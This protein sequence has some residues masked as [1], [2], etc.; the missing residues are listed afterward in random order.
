MSTGAGLSY[1]NINK[2]FVSAIDYMD[3]REILGKILD[4]RNEESCF[5]DVM[6]MFGVMKPTKAVTFHYHVNE[7]LYALGIVNANLASTVATNASP[8]PV[9][10]VSN[11]MVRVGDLVLLPSTNSTVR[12]AIVKT[13][14]GTTGIG[15]ASI[16]GANIA[17]SSGASLSFFSG[18]YGEGSG[19][20]ES[21]RYDATSYSGQLQ[22]FKDTFKITDVQWGSE[23]EVTFNGKPYVFK[24]AEFETALKFRSAISNA[25][26]L[27][28]PTSSTFGESATLTD[29]SG[30]LG[31]T[32][33]TTRGLD[34]WI[35][36]RGGIVDTLDYSNVMT[37]AD[38]KNLNAQL[39]SK[40]APKKY[41]VL[42]GTSWNQKNDDLFMNLGSSPKISATG[43][44]WNIN[45]N[46]NLDLETFSIY[47]RSFAKK[48]MDW[49]NHSNVISYTG[50]PKIADAAYYI[51][52]DKIK[53]QDGGAE[54]RIAVRYLVGEDGSN[55]KY[56]VKVA[57]GLKQGDNAVEED[58][59]SV[60]YAAT[61]GLQ[62][63]GTQHFVKQQIG[64]SAL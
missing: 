56:R 60:R 61:M 62:V 25:L 46:I 55:T 42:A 16:D 13:K 48:P 53:T 59:I 54:D 19:Y 23:V 3:K 64:A 44:V 39:D 49:F 32:V 52:V 47:G 8:A 50:A 31:N 36:N 30:G 21:R 40:R 27:A 26:L 12:T 22:I 34:S 10:L 35:T 43:A 6:E 20:P 63:L 1:G 29:G 17:L 15:L 57:D 11:S 28:E 38:W 2:S 9:V 51:P 41:L 33:S 14:T 58:S 37:L 4:V 5:L 45:K 18:A 7:E 24:K